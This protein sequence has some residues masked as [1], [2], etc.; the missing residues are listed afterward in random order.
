MD[1]ELN[2]NHLFLICKLWEFSRRSWTN[3]IQFRN[4][5]HCDDLFP[6]LMKRLVKHRWFQ[7]NL[8]WLMLWLKDFCE[9]E[10]WLIES[11][12]VNF[13]VHDTVRLDCDEYCWYW[14]F[15]TRPEMNHVET[16][17]VMMRCRVISN[18][19]EPWFRKREQ[20]DLTK[21]IPLNGV[22]EEA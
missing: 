8:P 17:L 10:K 4:Q 11:R 15:K 16:N 12:K 6:S 18:Q 13:M 22:Y 19:T 2:W 5:F 14:H 20:P 7:Q 9:E 3:V 1:F 21:T